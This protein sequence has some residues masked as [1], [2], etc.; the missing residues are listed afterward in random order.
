ME[1]LIHVSEWGLESN[2]EDRNYPAEYFELVQEN[3]RL[4]DKPLQTKRLSYFQDAMVRFGKNKYN[5][6]ATIILVIM[7]IMSII[8]PIL[9]PDRFIKDLNSELQTLP[10]RVPLLEKIGIFDGMNKYEDQPIDYDTI[11]P[12]T[13]LG[14]PTVGFD[15]EF[16]VIKQKKES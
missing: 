3:E 5:V 16:T 1:L 12:E 2:M 7:I 9:T 11:D 14:Y 10:P 6:I 4:L 13:G 15:V 8:V